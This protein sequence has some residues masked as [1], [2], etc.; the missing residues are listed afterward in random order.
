MR[1]GIYWLNLKNSPLWNVLIKIQDEV[2][3]HYVEK[4]VTDLQ[5][6]T[7]MQRDIN[8]TVFAGLLEGIHEASLREIYKE[9]RRRR[10]NRKAD[11]KGNRPKL[12][13]YSIN[14]SVPRL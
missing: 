13:T 11:N 4:L 9:G 7:Q 10:E 8:A 1:I 14:Q 5:A 12:Q 2:Y 6:S 3:N